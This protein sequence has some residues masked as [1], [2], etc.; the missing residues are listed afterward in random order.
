MLEAG[1]ATHLDQLTFAEADLTKDDGWNEA[2][3]GCTYVLHVASPLPAAPPKDEMELIIPAREGTRRVLRAARDA[4]VKRVVVTSS[5]AAIG[6]GH[7]PAKKSFTEESWTIPD[8]PGVNPYVRSKALAERAA[9]DFLEKEGG[10]LELA[11]V[12]PVGIFGP[13][14]GSD[15]VVR[16]CRVPAPS[17]ARRLQGDVQRKSKELAGLAAAVGSRCAR[18]DCGKSDQI[19]P[20]QENLGLRN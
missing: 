15:W 16:S 13:V 5:F 20:R 4:G 6:Y 7:G 12:N 9:W 10:S 14:L 8:G 2:A 3:E 17:G 11:V 19:W 18:C 1:E